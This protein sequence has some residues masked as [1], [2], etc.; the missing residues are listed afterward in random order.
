MPDHVHMLIAAE[1]KWAPSE[2]MKFVKGRSSFYLRKEFPKLKDIV[3]K[4]LWTTSFFVCSV[5]SSDEQATM[6]YIENQK[7]EVK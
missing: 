6:K 4:S 5:G 3:K 1:P 2:I 7:K